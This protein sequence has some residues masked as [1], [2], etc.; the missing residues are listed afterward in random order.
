MKESNEIQLSD[1]QRIFM[2]NALSGKNILVDACIGSGKTTAIQH[3]C[4]AFPVTKKVLYLTYN[5]LLKLDARQKIKND[6]VKVTN[7]HGFAYR[8]LVKIGVPTSANESVQNFNKLKPKIDSY[9][10]LIIDEYQDIELEFSELLEYIKANNP[11]IQIIAVG[12]MAQKVYDKTTLDVPR[13][14]EQFLGPHI[15]LSFT[16]CFRLP[17]DLAKKLGRIWKKDIIGVNDSCKVEVMTVPEVT[18]F[19]STQAPKDIL[20][21]GSRTGD[22]T[23]VLNALESNH[24]DTFNKKTVYAS[25]RKDES[26]GKVEPKKTS[27]IFTTFDS[28]KGLER[29]ISVVFDFTESYWDVRVKK[30]L[31]KYDIL[32]NVFCV[33]ASRGKEHIIFV[34]N[35][36]AILSEKT[37]S[38][39]PNL[40]TK[41]DNVNISELFDYKYPEDI[42]ACYSLLECTEID[43][44]DNSRILIK[45]T[46]ELIDLS[47]CIGIYQEAVFFD[48]DRYSI[49]KVIE[50]YFLIHKKESKDK[51]AAE[52]ALDEKILYLT[53][54]DTKQERY[55]KQ[56]ATPFVSDNERAE[57]VSRLSERFTPDE[58]VQVR[59]EIPFYDGNSD[60]PCFKALGLCD[61][62]K[63]EIVYELKFVKELSPVHFLQCACY[64][65]ALEKEKGVLWNT[66]NNSCYEIR[67]PDRG[68]F[69]DAVAKATTK[70]ELDRYYPPNTMKNNQQLK[71]GVDINEGERK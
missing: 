67:I 66:S 38:T 58:N 10:V 9:D 70:R 26:T 37:L 24:P 50:L 54:L 32:R 34:T 65:V 11:G 55:R 44:D 59:C 31:Q 16:K 21:L 61:V 53:S 52:L 5:K 22:M 23:E 8:E 39:D 49:D 13:F 40:A 14:M 43:A 7:Y 56:V 36:E 46:D 64:M 19:L 20:C 71:I 12:D 27:A 69:L 35:G 47:P 2:L 25:I 3:L 42:D 15:E 45:S 68:A 6:K 29:K 4:S 17:S 41:Y 63:D 60:C 57:L 30:P 18:D 33:A 28:S 62:L 51:H 48:Q 1:E